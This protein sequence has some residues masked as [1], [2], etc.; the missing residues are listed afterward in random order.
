LALGLGAPFLLGLLCESEKSEFAFL[1]TDLMIY[2]GAK[3][4]KL[5]A[6]TGGFS[7]A[8]TKHAFCKCFL[9]KINHTVR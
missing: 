5:F 1:A 6:R 7:Q 3:R 8:K 9:S 4:T 2:W